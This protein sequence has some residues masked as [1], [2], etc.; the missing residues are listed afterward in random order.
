MNI[1]ITKPYFDEEEKA[2]L[3]KPLESGWVVQGPFVAEFEKRFADFVGARQAVAVSNCTTA[4]HLSLLAAGVGPGDRVIIPSFTYVATAN[5]VEHTGAQPIFCDIELPTFNIDSRQVERLLKADTAHRIKA[6]V[7]VNLF[8]LCA[9]LPV[10]TELAGRFGVPLIEDSA[11]GFGSFIGEKHSG[12]FGSVGCFS[13]HPRKAI[14]TGEGGMIV[15][16]DDV[17]ATV[18]RS[19]RDHGA[20]KSDLQRHGQKGGALLP[21]FPRVG[22]NYR[23]T[24]FQGAMGVAQMGKAQKILLARRS[25]AK[26]YESDLRTLETLVP[27]MIP[28]GYV[29]GFQ[30]YVACYTEGLPG[31][32]LD[33]ETIERL[34]LKRN[35]L[36]TG[37]EE[38]GIATRQGTHAVHTLKYYRTTYGLGDSDFLQSFA[39]DRLSLALPLYYGMTEEEYAFV[40]DA[41]K[42]VLKR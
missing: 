38:R 31:E 9:D 7:P 18:L 41:L 23:M 24:D 12:T 11:C 3:I 28:E 35:Q 22:Y 19:L 17:W 36:M 29:S 34:H 6:I 39:A 4:L 25:W 42:S 30:S 5:A 1:P 26:R 37:L 8:G 27:P 33:L 16:D 10:L 21:E 40:I 14:T 13:F 15:T 20:E 2:L 32:A